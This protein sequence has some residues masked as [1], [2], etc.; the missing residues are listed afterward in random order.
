M[1]KPKG[2]LK[3]SKV[4]DYTIEVCDDN[5]CKVWTL[6]TLDH[7]LVQVE[8]DIDARLEEIKDGEDKID[9]EEDERMGILKEHKEYYEARLAEANNLGIIR[10]THTRTVFGKDVKKKK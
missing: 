4:D 8:K 1:I 10:K 9:V 6:E 7:S 3:F 2:K 5:G